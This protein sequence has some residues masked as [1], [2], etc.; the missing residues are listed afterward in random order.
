MN[1][2]DRRTRARSTTL[3]RRAV[4]GDDEVAFGG[5]GGRIVGIAE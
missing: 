5:Q 3:R 4:T 2:N 1:E